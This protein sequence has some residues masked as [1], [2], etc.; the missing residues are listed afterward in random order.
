MGDLSFLSLSFIF[1]KIGL[2]IIFFCRV[3][4]GIEKWVRAVSTEQRARGL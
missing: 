4:V 2:M 1:C 3:A